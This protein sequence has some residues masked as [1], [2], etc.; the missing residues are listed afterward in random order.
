MNNNLKIV[1]QLWL[2]SSTRI[3]KFFS[4][5]IVAPLLAKLY[6]GFFGR[7]SVSTTSCL[8]HK[9]WWSPPGVN[10]TKLCVSPV[11]KATASIHQTLH[12]KIRVLEKNRDLMLIKLSLGDLKTHNFCW[13]WLVTV[14]STSSFVSRLSHYVRVNYQISKPGQILGFIVGQ[15]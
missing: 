9:L 13:I 5:R 4:I 7:N 1:F 2:I 14:W 12:A 6:G 15:L 11:F 3:T 10:F 8:A